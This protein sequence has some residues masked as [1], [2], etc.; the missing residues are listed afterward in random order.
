MQRGLSSF[1]IYVIVS[2]FQNLIGSYIDKI[3]QPSP[4]ELLIR[5]NNKNINEKEIIYIK[6]S[7]LICTTQKVFSVPQKPS[8]FA[9]TCRKY[10]LNG[11]ITE[12]TQHEFDRIIKIKI[13]KK[14]GEYILVFELFKNGNIILL[15]PE[16]KIILPLIT[17]QWAHRT[18]RPNRTYNPPPSQINPLHI[19]EKQFYEL[20]KKSKKDIV[21]TLAVTINL[22]GTY[23]EEI[24]F[25]S[26][27]DK[28]KKPTDLD[29]DLITKL[30]VEF[31]NLLEIFKTKNFNPVY[32]KEKEEIVDIL[33]FK[34]KSYNNYEFVK[35]NRF[36]R[37]L[38]HFI[39]VKKPI[40]QTKYQNKIEKLQRQI[41]Q[42]KK[43]L[44]SFN[45]NIDRKKIEGDIIYLNFK[46][47]EELLD[48]INIL[49]EQKEKTAGIE[50]INTK[51]IVK[52]FDPTS[53]D[54]IVELQNEHGEKFEVELDFRKTVAENA[55]NAYQKSKKL[56]EKL[57]GAKQALDNT[58]K[59]IKTLKEKDIVEKEG[60]REV[61][62][63]FWFERFRW[64]ISKEGNIVVAGKDAKTN[65]IIVKKYLKEK[66]RYVHAD[67]HG[68]PSCIVKSIDIH[69]N[70]MPISDKTLEESCI[71]AAAYSKAWNQFADAQ[72]Y[73]VFPKQVSKTP[74][75][76]EFVPKGAF[77]IRGKRN[78]YRCKLEIAVGEI[79]I[80][81]IKKIMAGPVE[82]VKAQ[83]DKYI[84]IQS[85]D[86]KKD[87]IAKKLSNIFNTSVETIQRILPPGNVTIL[88]TKGFEIN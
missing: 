48:E 31:R 74:Q 60:K 85:G 46:Q 49:L 62:K 35:T 34:F 61:G 39:I 71:F 23:A 87:V 29:G 57:K 18:I 51:N 88:K 25:K 56:Q 13:Q 1:D 10:L 7:D 45:Q 5:I 14:E 76:G 33:P 19:G 55:E 8:T 50:Q 69:D 66:D 47:C 27:I 77:I 72:A 64:F 41:L 65:E 3:Y 21:R 38:E 52:S 32:V 54:L 80:D 6:N 67:V 75:S 68:A 26:D 44:K 22:S 53:N 24:C 78:H 73:W 42:Q 9:M 43:T 28:N 15:N 58:Q 17:Q 30:Y 2:E 82:S 84:V 86:I 4:D 20:L 16:E 59:Q 12:I 37:G 79:K 36:C 63:Q 70:D 81:N 40:Q 11:R 83:S